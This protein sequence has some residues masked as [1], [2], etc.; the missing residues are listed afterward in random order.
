MGHL[1]EKG[2]TVK[3]LAATNR[4]LQSIKNRLGVPDQLRSCHTAMV[5]NYVIEGHVPA[6]V[7]LRLLR[8]KPAV[9]GIAVPGMPIGSPGM[10]GPNP[11]PPT[12]P[13]LYLRPRGSDT[14][15]RAHPALARE[16]TPPFSYQV[17]SH[18]VTPVTIPPC[19]HIFCKKI[20]SFFAPP[21]V[22]SLDLNPAPWRNS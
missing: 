21:A 3:S 8:E 17:L 5:G 19:T 15:L 2:F 14:G 18:C 11:Q 13:G 9:A 16:G 10:E 20:D 1:Q 6:L 22:P 12:L 7:I 4:E